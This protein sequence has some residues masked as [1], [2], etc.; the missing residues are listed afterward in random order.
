MSAHFVSLKGE[1]KTNEDSHNI[2]LGLNDQGADMAKVNY[3]GVYDGHG[4]GFVS[5]FLSNNLPQFFIAKEVKYPLDVTYVN[6]VYDEVQKILFTKHK[7]DA[8][9]CGSTCLI[10]CH[11]KDDQNQDF[12]NV[13]NTGDCRSVLCRNNLGIP[14][15]RDHKPDWHDEKSRIL[16]L[17]GQIYQEKDSTTWRIE[18]L[19]VSRAFGDKSASKYVTHTPDIFKYKLTKKDRFA[20]IAC[21]GLWDVMSS[22]EAVNLVLKECYDSDM[23]RINQ[24]VNISRKLA[25][26]AINRACEDN[27][28]CIVVFFE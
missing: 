23:K 6:K 7:K 25:E 13:M 1:R 4:G 22:Q 14:L 27:V 17:G 28:T 26:T 15:T 12:L 16:Q 9:E 10:V 2:I 21:D 11:F 24:R 20:I 3:Y 8:T 19:S 18:G 5:K